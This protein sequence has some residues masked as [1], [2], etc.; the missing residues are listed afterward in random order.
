MPRTPA[1]THLGAGPLLCLGITAETQAS[2]VRRNTSAIFRGLGG[3][4]LSTL[5]GSHPLVGDDAESTSIKAPLKCHVRKGKS[6]HTQG[7]WPV[8]AR[9]W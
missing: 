1:E 2:E 9:F 5:F 6:I 7:V 8:K 4:R 3:S